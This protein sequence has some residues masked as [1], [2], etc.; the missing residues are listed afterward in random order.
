MANLNEDMA[1]IDYF[2]CHASEEDLLSV[3]HK[4]KFIQ[5]DKGYNLPDNW[6]VKARYIFAEQMMYERENA[7]I[8]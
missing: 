3:K 8:Y 4:V 6:R 2:A 5:T 7:L 1:L